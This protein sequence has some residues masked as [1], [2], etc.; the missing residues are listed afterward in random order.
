LVALWLLVV[1][2]WVELLALMLVDSLLTVLGEELLRVDSEEEP[3]LSVELV[4][5]VLSE[6]LD[7]VELEGLLQV[8]NS[9]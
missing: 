4:L 7:S 8:L 3:V 6:V 5:S 9:L 1:L 2:V